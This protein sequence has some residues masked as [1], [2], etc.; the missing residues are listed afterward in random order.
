MYLQNLKIKI[1]YDYAFVSGALGVFTAVLFVF[2][3]AF[4][5]A[6]L[7]LATG[8]VL[9]ADLLIGF[10]TAALATGVSVTFVFVT[11]SF[12]RGAF[13]IAAFFV[14]VPFTVVP[15]TVV[16]FTVVPFADV[17]FTGAFFTGAFFTGVFVTA[18]FA[19]GAVCAGAL[20]TVLA[21]LSVAG[22]ARLAF[23]ASVY[24]CDTE[25]IVP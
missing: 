16:P 21:F 25:L 6:A 7:K 18:A 24:C 15:F 11:V 1:K 10:F 3:G 22:V 12:V 9:A 2:A 23:K 20:L 5:S 14:A 17:L 4:T 13:L 19:T 8:C